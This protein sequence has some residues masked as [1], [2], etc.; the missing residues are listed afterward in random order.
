MT[1]MINIFGISITLILV[2]GCADIE[3]YQHATLGVYENEL[4]DRW[5]APTKR[6]TL[7]DSRQLLTWIH[8][9]G[10]KKTAVISKT[11]RVEVAT[12]KGTCSPR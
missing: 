3:Y 4:I 6:T 7:E 2:V 12:A 10:C 8:D 1:R 5:G 11:R 9:S